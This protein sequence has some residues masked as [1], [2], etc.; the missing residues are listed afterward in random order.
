MPT[1]TIKA[2]AVR[3]RAAAAAL[4]FG[5]TKL[6][7]LIARGVIKAVKSGK[8]LLIPTAELENYLASLPAAKLKLYNPKKHT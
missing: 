8:H 6:D 2:L 7:E 3:R 4:G 1:T 5:T